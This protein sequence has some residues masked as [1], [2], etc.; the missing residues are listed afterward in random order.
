MTR[1]DALARERR[2]RPIAS[3][4]ELNAC[5]ATLDER[6]RASCRGSARSD[7]GV[8]AGRFVASRAGRERGASTRASALISRRPA[9]NARDTAPIV[10]ARARCAGTR[11]ATRIAPRARSTSDH[12]RSGI[13]TIIARDGPA[14]AAATI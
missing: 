6:A 7:L 12:A 1:C 8:C 13:G 10:H 5:R 2:A 11:N 14:P 4:D 3:S 9:S